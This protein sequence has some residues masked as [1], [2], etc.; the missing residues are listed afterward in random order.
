MEAFARQAERIA[1]EIEKRQVGDYPG[2]LAAALRYRAAAARADACRARLGDQVEEQRD[3]PAQRP[4]GEPAGAPGGR[5]AW[6]PAPGAGR[7]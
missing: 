5:L 3:T 7:R 4:R 2:F 1:G 6:I